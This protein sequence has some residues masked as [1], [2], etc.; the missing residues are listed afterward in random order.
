[1]NR[2]YLCI[3]L[4]SFYASVEC[5]E[6]GL[7]P[8]KSNLV[9]ADPTRG[10]GAICLAI[11]PHMKELGIKNRCRIYEI[12]DGVDY[13]TA[14]PRMKKYIEY[15]ANI[16]GIYLEYVAKEDIH[17]YSID[18]AFLD[19]TNYLK[20][21]KMDA[22]SLGKK[23]MQSIYDATFITATCGVGTNLYLAKIALDLIAKH[24]SDYIGFLDRDKFIQELSY[25][26]PLSDFWGIG[27]HIEARLKRLGLNNM[28]DI[29][30]CDERVLFREFGINARLIIDH[31]KGIEP[32]TI[33]DIKE[34]RPKNKS[35][36]TS[37]ILF[38][39]YNMED[40]KKVLIEMLDTVYLELIKLDLYTSKIGFFVGYSKDQENTTSVSKKLEESTNSFQKLLEILLKEYNLHV[41]RNALIRRLGIS[42]SGLSIKDNYQL[43]LFDN[44]EVDKVGTTINTIKN[45]Y[46]KNYIFRGVSL[47]DRATGIKRNKLIGG[48]NAE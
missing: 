37:Q 6:R 32:C 21:Y 44:E 14:M 36:S 38:T 30:L 7:D 41:S 13:I 18:E 19:V 24:A 35:I 12:P 8:M 17:V 16:Y 39:D 28:H 11:S 40:A 20:L 22:V 15:S 46:G 5:V 27:K 48:H 10:N 26:E 23:I 45:K 2:S 1:M 47:S 43:S 42:L 3:D 25:Y 4:K 31:S 9:V 33:K 29:S 34:Y